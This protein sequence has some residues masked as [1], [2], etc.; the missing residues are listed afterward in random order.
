MT[1]NPA[2]REA[3]HDVVRRL[4]QNG[5]TA[6]FVGGCVRD[7]L[8]G[9]EPR[10][11]DVATSARPEQVVR[12]FRRSLTV[13][14]QFGVVI[15]VTGEG[16]VEVATF[17]SDGAYVDGRRPTEVEFSDPRRDSERRDFTVNG[18]FLDPDTGEVLDYVGGREDLAANRLRAIGD[19]VARFRED[20]LRMLR[21]VRFVATHGMELDP[22]T[23]AAI[24]EHAA[25]IAV[26][27][28]E[29]INAELS[30]IL[31]SGRSAA[32]LRL[33]RSL[34]L[35]APILPELAAMAGV[36]QPPEFHRGDVWTHT[37]LALEQFDQLDDG[38]LE[39][40]LA[41]LFH[42][43]GKPPTFT[44]RERIRFDGHDVVGAD[45]T[46]GIL[47]RLRYPAHV[48]DEV[49]ELVRRHLAFLQIRQ[50]RPAKLKRF[51][52]S[53]LADSHI[54]LHRL[55]SLASRGDLE[56]YEWMLEQ[57]RLAL[58]EPPP[59]LRLVTGADL[60][61]AGHTPGPRIGVALAALEDEILEG[62]VTT[63]EEGLAWIARSYPPE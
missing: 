17:R 39:L 46:T 54:A 18:L 37:L 25:D 62:R 33:L 28:W 9:R 47:R 52:L 13:G 45:M 35:L 51:M 2:G 40:A 56:A 11:Y 31:L 59:P 43:V 20:K 15:V 6:Y 63:R 55:D 21:A 48:V 50:W 49:T 3:A 44:V 7:E 24:E 41:A 16:E 14:A 1:A 42:D 27:S 57:R 8:I 26:V 30:R 10:E 5:F 32:G 22:R 29:R 38:S 61:A 53:P 4:R 60:L 34:G 36:E 23:S 19:P 12:L 58:T